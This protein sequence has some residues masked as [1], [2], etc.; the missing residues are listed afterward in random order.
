MIAGLDHLRRVGSRIW[1][2][3]RARLVVG[4]L[5]PPG[6]AAP[7]GD[8]M[9]PSLK[10]RRMGISSTVGFWMILRGAGPE[11]A[12][13]RPALVPWGSTCFRISHRCWFQPR[14]LPVPT[15]SSPN[16]VLTPT[17]CLPHWIRTPHTRTPFKS[18]SLTGFE[19]WLS[20]PHS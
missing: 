6:R 17:K 5:Q 16:T 18:P 14:R 2:A 11:S 15:S 12:R 19:H 9:R 10:F 13:F 3:P 7:S 8:R 4:R 20:A 1:G